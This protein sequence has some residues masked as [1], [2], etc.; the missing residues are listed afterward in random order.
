M[1]KELTALRNNNTWTLVPRPKNSNVVGSKWMFRTKLKPYGSLNCHKARLVARGFT[2]IPDIDF[3]HTF[4]PVVKASTI[5]VVL[6]LAVIN[7]WHLHQLDV[8]NAFLHGNLDEV[9]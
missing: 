4:N 5:R 6:S 2:Q 1:H 9:I 3:T 8:N 7:N